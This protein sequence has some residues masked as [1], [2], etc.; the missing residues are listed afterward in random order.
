[1]KI[2]DNFIWSSRAGIVFAYVPKVA[3]T[4]WKCVLRYL[5]GH[6]DYLDAQIA[7][8]RQRSGLTYLTTLAQAE[9]LI[10]NPK[11]PKLT[12]VRNPYSRILS[13][14]LNKIK[15]FAYDNATVDRDSYFHMVFQVIDAYR[16]FACPNYNVVSF[17]CF[18]RWIELS[19]DP[20]VHN[21]HWI[22]Q[23]SILGQGDVTF[24]YI[25]KLENILT[26]APILLSLMGCNIPFPSQQAVAFPPT[27]A[28]TLIQNYYSQDEYD[29]VRRI[30]A[31]DFDHLGYNPQ[32]F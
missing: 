32:S 23:T 24:D 31:Q 4:N 25:G 13:A 11:V 2:L 5:D 26:D 19:E 17:S 10:K 22:P 8:D 14:Y 18:L 28:S 16:K 1:M 27:H 3:C 6:S 20:L 15:P 21:E 9:D 29:A 30:Y 12:C 7:H